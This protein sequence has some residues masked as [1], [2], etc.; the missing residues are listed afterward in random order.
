ML[1]SRGRGDLHARKLPTLRREGFNH[2]KEQTFRH[3]NRPI[4]PV[5]E[6]RHLQRELR[7]F[8]GSQAQPEP[9]VPNHSGYCARVVELPAEKST[10]A[11]SAGFVWVI[12]FSFSGQTER[13][14]API[15]L[16]NHLPRVGRI[17][18]PAAPDLRH[19][20]RP[21]ANRVH[22]GYFS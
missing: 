22:P 2:V 14:G 15:V 21:L 1:Y 7:V 6:Q 12:V 11:N 17:L 16:P 8:I 10:R 19:R 5:H 20:Q 18:A 3:S 13:A 4:L 9:A